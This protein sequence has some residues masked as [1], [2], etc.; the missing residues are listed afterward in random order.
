MGSQSGINSS[1]DVES[2]MTFTNT[3]TPV[4]TTAKL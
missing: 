2:G 1:D 3:L 4:T